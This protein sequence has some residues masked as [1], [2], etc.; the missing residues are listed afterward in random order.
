M[1]LGSDR[2]DFW[3]LDLI[4]PERCAACGAGERIVC[5]PCLASLQ[6]LRAPLCAR[7]GAPTAWPVERCGEC[8]GRRLSFVR[9]RAAVAY[10]GPARTLVAAWKERGRRPLGRVFAGLVAEVVPRP[11]VDVVTF[12][13]GDRERVLRRGQNA[14]EALARLVAL[15]W[16]LPV[17][18]L[19]ARRRRVEPQRGLPRGDRRLN[20]RDAFRANPSPRRVALMDD[21][22]TTGSTVTSAATEL[23]RAGAREVQVVTF[24]RTVRR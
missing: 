3:L 5:A 20:V 21:V 13:P 23:R 6:L 1:G 19:L 17:E 10:D 9:A 12:V 8:A 16:E 7:C 22:Y 24:A 14:P 2:R 15:E 4:V 18:P 11:I